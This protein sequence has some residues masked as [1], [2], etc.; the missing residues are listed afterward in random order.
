MS[1]RITILFN[2]SHLSYS[3]TIIGLY[4]RLAK[5]FDVTIVADSPRYFDNKPLPGRNVIYKKKVVGRKRTELY[6]RVFQVLGLFD[7]DIRRLGKM[8]LKPDALY[9]FAW[10][11]KYLAKN[12]ADIIIAVDF[13]NLLIAQMLGKKV[14]FVSLEI[15]ENDAA[16]QNCDFENVNSVVIQT[17]ERFAYLFGK[18]KLKTFLIQNAPVFG[19]QTASPERRGLVYCGTAWNPFGF[20]HC[21]EFLRQFPEYTLNVK[22]AIKEFDREKVRVEYA[23]LLAERRLSIDDE[24]LEDEAVVGYLRNFRIGFC[25]YNFE[26]EWVDTFNYH[27]APSG[28]MFKYFAAGVPV[29][30]QDIIGLKPVAEFDC[31]VLIADLKPESIKKAIEKIEENFEYYSRNCLQAA[32]HYS[33]DKTTRRLSNIWRANNLTKT[34]YE[35][36]DYHRHHRTGRRV[37][38]RFSAGQRLRSS[39]HQTPLVAD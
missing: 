24:Y 11:R 36:S 1:K 20:Y 6:R 23:D 33:F 22:G 39:R 25:F 13:N 7:R 21:L 26:I 34:I 29:V 3:P 30:G 32:A 17:R 28:K 10:T 18:R 31:G 15:P 27:S 16:R 2:G 14:E 5:K 9:D 8:N 4:D 37:S 35:K 38:G 19:E 12:P